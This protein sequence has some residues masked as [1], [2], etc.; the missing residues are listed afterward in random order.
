MVGLGGDQGY[1]SSIVGLG[2]ACEPRVDS[3]VKNVDSDVDTETDGDSGS[4]G[5]DDWVGDDG[6]DE[7]GSTRTDINR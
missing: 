4:T 3:A 6:T 7:D 2:L 1:L 5:D